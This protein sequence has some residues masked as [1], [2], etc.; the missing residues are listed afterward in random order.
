[1]LGIEQQQ[2]PSQRG[3]EIEQ[4]FQCL[5]CLEAAN[6]ADQ[7]REHA[8]LRASLGKFPFVFI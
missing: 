1:M 6:H 4:H 8:G 2:S 7:W 5:Q 3:A